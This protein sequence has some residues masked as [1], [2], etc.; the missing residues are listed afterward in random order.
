MGRNV[1]GQWL[2]TLG[3]LGVK[4]K[5]TATVVQ[6][7]E[8]AAPKW[9]DDVERINQF[10]FYELGQK[11][12][13]L[14]AYSGDIKPTP[15]LW[16]EMY[17]AD[18]ALEDLLKGIPIPVG[19]CRNAARALS[20]AITDVIRATFFRKGDDGKMQFHLPA[21]NADAI[22]EWKWN[23]IKSAIT[24]FETVFSAEMREVATYF[25][26][27]REIYSTP[28][29]VDSADE[30][31]PASLLGFLPQ[32][33]RDD[34]KAAGRCLAFNLLSASG[35]HVARVVEGT[36]EL[37]Y[38]LFSGKPGATLV[39]WYEY[40][41]ELTAIAAAKPDPCPSE[42]TLAEFR[43]M[44]SDYRNPIMHPRVTLTESDARMLFD[45]GESLIIA[46]AEE[47]KS[48]REQG[49]VQTALSVVAAANTP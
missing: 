18:N 3:G 46:M 38:Q 22:D 49:G 44:K 7:C 28:A 35:F 6:L 21:D 4:E 32:K 27:R 12:K 17:V 1:D 25:V 48:I 13:A 23:S 39:S 24:T 43:Q 20:D 8:L 37:Y 14:T 33:T 47:I 29:L 26:P 40:E 42:K 9:G 45:N 11:L 31:F 2:A 19:V 15:A 36:V 16:V 5:H 10:S 30:S 41:K 34:W